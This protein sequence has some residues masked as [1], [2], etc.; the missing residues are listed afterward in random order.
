MKKIILYIILIL[1][2]DTSAIAQSILPELGKATPFTVLAKTGINSIGDTKI[3]GNVGVSPGTVFTGFPQGVINGSTEINTS[4]S[5]GAMADLSASYHQI[6][7]L[8][9][10]YQMAGQELGGKTLK[11]GIY[12]VDNHTQINGTL[13]LDNNGN[14]NAVFIFQINGD[15]TVGSNARISFLETAQPKVKNVFWQ[16]AG[17][18]TLGN[19]TTFRGS[20]LALQN[21]TA[22]SGATVYG[23]LF[24]VSGSVGLTNNIITIPTDLSVTIKKS[25]GNAQ[26]N[27]FVGGTVTYTITAHNAGPIGESNV[28][29]FVLNSGLTYISSKAPPGSAY[30][31]SASQWSINYFGAGATATLELTTEINNNAT[32]ILLN[33]VT[34]LGD[35]LDESRENNEHSVSICV[36]PSDPGEISGPVS[37][38]AGQEVVFS[39]TPTKVASQYNWTFPPGW[40]IV[41]GSNGST[42][43]VIASTSEGEVSVTAQNVCSVSEPSTRKVTIPVAPSLAPGPISASYGSANPCTGRADVTYTIAPVTGAEYYE[44]AV[45]AGWQIISG[46]KSTTITV[47]TGSTAGQ[48]TV[49]AVNACGPSTAVNLSVQPS[50]AAPAPPTAISGNQAPCVGETVVYT[51]SGNPENTF[52]TWKFPQGWQVLEGGTSKAVK[53]IVGS[54]AANVEAAAINGCGTSTPVTYPV[55]PMAKPEPASISGTLL[56]C[57]SA[58]GTTYTY[59]VT[60]KSASDSYFWRVSGNLALVEGQGTSEVKIKVTTAVVSGTIYVSVLNNCGQSAESSITVTPTTKPA[61]P[62]AI[63][64]SALQPCAGE[65]NLQY[66]IPAVPGAVS[67]TW[68]LPPGWVLV[69][70]ADGTSITVKAGT[71][72]GTVAVSAVN[73][74]G[75]G[76][77]RSLSVSPSL[78]SPNAPVSI[79]GNVSPCVNAKNVT[80]SVQEIPGATEY[81]WQVPNGWTITSGTGSATIQVTVGNSSGEI[82]VTSKNNCGSSQATTLAVAPATAAPPSPGPITGNTLVTC[83]NDEKTVYSISE[84]S[85]ATRYEWAVPDG[86]SITDGQGTLTIQVKAGTK[87]GNIAVKAI[88]SCGLSAASVLAVQSGAQPP[89]A[90]VAISGRNSVCAQEEEI[91][92]TISAVNG[93]TSYEWSVSGDWTITTGQGTTSIKVKAGVGPSTISVIARNNCGASQATALAVRTSTALPATP[94]PISETGSLCTGNIKVEYRIAPVAGAFSYSWSVPNGWTFTQSSDGTSI[95]VT[96]GSASGKIKVTAVNGCGQSSGSEINVSPTNAPPGTPT[97][98]VAGSASVCAKEKGLTYFIAL[99]PGATTYTWSVPSDWEITSGQGSN[100]IT[101][102][103]GK[104]SGEIAVVAQ[105]TCGA[106]P[107]STL[108]VKANQAPAAPGPII[109]E[110]EACSGGRDNTYSVAEVPGATTYEWTVP[111]GWT[112]T[113]PATSSSITVRAGTAEGE[114]SVKAINSCGSSTATVL[115]VSSST[116]AP[117]APIAIHGTTTV[118]IGSTTLLQYKV[119]SPDN[120][121]SSY[122]WTLSAGWDIESGQGTNTITVKPPKTAGTVSVAAK[123]GCGVSASTSLSVAMVSKIPA[124]PGTIS[125]L[126]QVCSNTKDVLFSISTMNGVSHYQWEVPQG[127]SIT[128][129]QGTTAIKVTAGSA[130]GEVRVTAVNGCGTSAARTKTVTTIPIPATPGQ[131]K[132]TAY[133][134]AGATKISYS[135]DAVPGATSYQ[136]KVPADWKITT[137]Q[138]SV[139]VQVTVGKTSGELSV[140]AVNK[141]GTSEAGTLAVFSSTATSSAPGKI[142]PEGAAVLCAGQTNLKYSILPV[143]SASS[144]LWEVPDGWEITKGQGTSAVEVKAGP[145][146]GEVSV[147]VING[148][149]E[150]SPSVLAVNID[151]STPLQLSAITGQADVCSSQKGLSYSVPAVA[152]VNTY[153]WTVPDG[154]SITSGQGTNTVVVTAGSEGGSL[155]VAASNNCHAASARF[156]STVSA[157]PAAPVVILDESNPCTG[158]Q[159]SIAAVPGATSYTWSVP[160]GWSISSGQGSTAIKVAAPAGSQAG[161]IHVVANNASTTACSSAATAL[162]ADPAKAQADLEFANALSPNGDRL[163]DTWKIRNIENYQENDLVIINRWGA[164]VYRQKGYRNNWDGGSLSEGTYFYVLKVK[165]CDG[166]TKTYQGYVMIVR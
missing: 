94:G 123:N 144:Y 135:I 77:A 112:I 111:T 74:C 120:T 12:R 132:G 154:W 40:Q 152:G 145:T 115:K 160:A 44:W 147:K 80:Y 84:V 7:A 13:T 45:P 104:A 136:W 42:I 116:T 5:Q 103:A 161:T 35:G 163:N 125:G 32:A 108:F 67:Y 142:T 9:P 110:K 85:G 10:T 61:Q 141:C 148:C 34:I 28:R 36:A 63:N 27:Y 48:V 43:E 53:V 50:V 157:T 113:S 86:W 71:S 6:S 16:V 25:A 101:V 155:Q 70:P 76:P 158:L 162:L 109:G 26:G 102:T 30:D 150:S 11:P 156:T 92:Y 65:E 87:A 151:K 146:S 79:S 124:T 149:G 91:I 107:A 88:N 89:S 105:N 60:P 99:V 31:P 47:Q 78:S 14:P 90:P 2:I 98:I 117:P 82:R 129:G 58:E 100:I 18:A 29:I 22:R 72:S 68:T 46:E 1:I 130:G 166:V 56:P 139:S 19:G 106:S 52:Y 33:S 3:N 118:C 15:L 57:A 66:S 4:A 95:L 133:Q 93:A 140:V 51:A 143:P 137:G 49:R 97:S 138:G 96:V 38:C 21:I 24:S 153:H 131:I 59:S 83:I 17:E 159:Y 41:S 20:L 128:E 75:P 126:A 8:A 64:S 62:S 37:A 164:E 73:V 39:V 81:A 54:G 114:I 165:L 134:C 55:S 23:R 69:G 122:F 127:W 121:S 119:E